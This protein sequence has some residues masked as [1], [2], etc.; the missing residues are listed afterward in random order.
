MTFRRARRRRG[1]E[2][3]PG[4]VIRI[5]STDSD[6]S[7]FAAR[8]WKAD[9]SDTARPPRDVLAAFGAAGEPRTIRGGQPT[10]WT[11]ADLVL[12]PDADPLLQ[13]WLG[14]TRARLPRI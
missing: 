7:V 13:E 12:K 6:L 2:M 3:G 10:S 4:T 5:C 9:L 11:V 14:T 8:A 1:T